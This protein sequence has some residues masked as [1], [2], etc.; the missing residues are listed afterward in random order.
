MN[1][2]EYPDHLENKLPRSFWWL[3]AT[4]FAGALNDNIFRLLIVFFLIHVNGADKAATISAMAGAVFVVPFLLFSSASGILA[5]R[6]SKQRI[7]VFV[8]IAEVFIMLLGTIAFFAGH[9]YGLY[10]TLFL[11]ASQSALFAPA[12]YGIVPE[13]VKTGQLSRA[14]SFL[15]SFTYLAIIMGAA[16]APLLAIMTSNYGLAT[17]G[18]IGIS[19][20]GL[21][22]S[23]K[24]ETTSSAGSIRKPSAFFLREIWG[25]LRFIR[26]DGYLILAVIGSAYF[27]FIG[28]FSQI[29]LIPYGIETLHLTHEQSGYLFFIAAI[30]IGIGCYLSGRLSGRNIEFGVVPIGAAGLSFSCIALYLVPLKL[31]A[32]VT[33]VFALGISSGLFIVPLQSFIQFRSP[34]DRRG[35]ILATSGFLGWVGVL[36]ASGFVFILSGRLQMSASGSFMII[37]AMTMLMMLTTLAVLPDFLIRFIALVCMKLFY[38]IKVIGIENIPINGPALLVPN[39]VSWVDALLLTATQQRRIRF[40]MERSI[41]NTWYLTPLFKLMGVIPISSD[42]PPKEILR[43]IKQAREAI[44]E[45][46]MVCIFA[47]GAVTRSGMIQNFREG[48][49]RIIKGTG[50]PVI[51]VYLGGLWGSIFSYAHGRLVSRWPVMLPYP[52]TIIFG[53]PL[54]ASCNVHEVKQ[55]V[56]ELSCEYFNSKR[57]EHRSLPETLITSARKHWKRHAISDTSGKRLRFGEMLT[58][59]FIFSAKLKKVT[60]ESDKVGVLLPPSAG[61]ALA[62][63]T[64]SIL[65]KVP[66]NLNYT[67]SSESACSAI[68]QCGIKYVITSKAFIE[69]VSLSE[70]PAESIYLE[71]I[72]GQFTLNEKFSAWLKARVIPVGLLVSRKGFDPDALATIIFSSGSTGEPKGVMLSHHNII[73][74]V[75]AVRTVLRVTPAD[76]ICSALPFFHSLGFTGTIWLPLLSGFSVSY[77]V[78]PMDGAKIAETVFKNRS[79]MLLSTP[80]FLT[81]YIR[82]AEPGDFATLRLVITGAEKLRKNIADS[83]H[84]KFGIRPLEGYGVTELSPVIAL[85]IP[86]ADMDG[87]LHIGA[88]ENSVGHPV[89]GVAVKIVDT[90]TKENLPA[91]E[92]G[93]ILVKGP[94]VMKGYLNL[95]QHTAE[96]KHDG[97]YV[98]GDIGF[99][100]K[101]GFMYITDRLSR[102]SKIAGEMVP[103][104]RIED[105]FYTHL[106]KAELSVAVT[107][108]PDERKGEK[109]VVLFTK[110]AGDRQTL[111]KILAESSLPNLW[112]PDN[113]CYIPIDAIPVLGSGKLDLKGLK[114][115]ALASIGNEAAGSI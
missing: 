23:L 37:G 12:K 57:S 100:D 32:I 94:N 1:R 15:E 104:K 88:K 89:P 31:A 67:A 25:N 16:L 33:A 22:T 75:E 111:Q 42:D 95:P 93:L 108:V 96:V 26:K 107:S 60:G 36:L 80:T 65:G 19:I 82:K 21:L 68:K 28:A 43:S 5:D 56:E 64:L 3:N 9:E 77:H 44:V 103:H 73:S 11:M 99:T 29:N 84:R 58:A 78:N 30:G 66:V 69:K 70:L 114:Q 97:W 113:N 79:T 115:L 51:P 50:S 71:E 46:Y 83:F 53:Q 62:N 72:S 4:Q 7:I 85:N 86:D 47:E 10:F 38:R 105:E 87:V 49:E 18:C 90:E 106:N 59:V 98:T 17:I 81:V 45:G 112:K 35:E 6:I 14:N 20:A 101:D 48:M 55:A 39:H 74:N 110:E 24:I 102:F 109:L 61:G 41:Y 34:N 63:L 76:N 13:L 91:N 52:V 8:K 40:L 27:M 54:A 92:S 2:A